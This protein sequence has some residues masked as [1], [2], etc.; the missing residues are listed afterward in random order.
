MGPFSDEAAGG[1][2]AGMTTEGP[3]ISASMQVEAQGQNSHTPRPRQLPFRSA[4][5]SWAMV[6]HSC[7]LSCRSSFLCR[8]QRDRLQGLPLSS[9]F[10]ATDPHSQTA[11]TG[12]QLQTPACGL[13]EAPAPL[14][15]ICREAAQ[16]CPTL[17]PVDC[18]LPGSSVHGILQARPLQSAAI[19]FSRGSSQTRDQTHVSC[20]SR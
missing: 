10:M 19:S 7:R 1:R 13:G 8:R 20:I 11:G 14:C 9:H 4:G 6:A 3:G 2:Q 12:L 18:S 16:S 5:A 15:L 17:T